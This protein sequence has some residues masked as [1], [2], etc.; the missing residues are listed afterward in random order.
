MSNS[1]TGLKSPNLEEVGA[2]PLPEDF[3]RGLDGNSGV[4]SAGI[5]AFFFLI[6]GFVVLITNPTALTSLMPAL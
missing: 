2:E 4:N 6:V 5:I 3:I 1:D